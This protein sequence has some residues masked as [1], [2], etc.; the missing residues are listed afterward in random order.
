MK[1][2]YILLVELKENK[3]IQI[4]KLGN[5]TFEKGFYVYAGSALNGLEQRVNRH[6]RNNKK[7]HWHIDYLL[8]HGKIVDIFY[9]ENDAKEE[10]NFAKKFEEKLT[11]TPNFGCSDCNCG[12]H[13]F[14]GLKNEIKTIIRTFNM[15][16]YC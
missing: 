1:G 14:F 15:I 8:T 13:L 11:H 10:C 3:N 9:K 7:K 2:S 12:S 16:P 5:V 4:G 6:L